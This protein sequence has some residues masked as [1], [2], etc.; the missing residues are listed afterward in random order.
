M[1]IEAARPSLMDDASKDDEERRLESMLFGKAYIPAPTNENV[2]VVS[3]DEEAVELVLDG[4][5]ELQ[6]MLDSDVR[7]PISCGGVLT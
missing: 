6:N 7:A 3:D 4:E 1:G 5:N 2:L